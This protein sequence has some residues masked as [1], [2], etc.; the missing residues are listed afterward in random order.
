VFQPKTRPV[1][2]KFIPIAQVNFAKG[3]ISTLTDSRMP[4]DG[5]ARM[6]NMWLEQDSVPRPRPPFIKYGQDYLGI[7]IGQGTF[8]KI[9]AGRP[10]YWEISMQVV[11]GVAGVYIRKDGGDW[12]GVGGNY[13]T[14]AWTTFTPA[15]AINFS[16]AEDARVYISNRVNNMSYYDIGS[17]TI[18]QYTGLATPSAPTVVQ[19][20]L[21][22][23]NFTQYYR[24]TANNQGGESAAS[25]SGSVPISTA[26]DFWGSGESITVSWPTVTGAQSYSI[27]TADISGQEAYL[28]TV[29][30]TTFK[31]DGTVAI[32]VFKLAPNNDSS[33]G[34]KLGQLINMDNQLFG[35]DDPD[36]PSYLWYSG[37]AQH[38]GDFS[39]N[40]EGGGYVGIDYGGDTLPTIPFSFQDGKGNPV[41]SILTHGAAGRGKLLHMTFTTTQ[42]GSTSVTYPNVYEASSKDG[43]PAP[44]GV[45]IYN[46][47]AYYCT[48]TAF[49][50]TGI[51]PNV[52]NILSTD[53]ISNQL[54]PDLARI[55]LAALAGASALEYLGKIYFSLPVDGSSKNNTVWILDLTRGGL[56]ILE[57]PV[58]IDHMWLY[59]DN[60]GDAHLVTLQNNK[61]LELDLK[62][63]STPTQDN[64][65]PFVTDLRSGAMVFDKGGVAMFS[66]YFTYFKFLAVQGVIDVSID[67]IVQD[68][69]V[70]QTLVTGQINAQAQIS[71]T[72]FGQMT[73]SNPGANL[74]ITF[75]GNVGP[76]IQTSVAAQT[77]PLE[78]DEIVNQESW[79]ITTNQA[80]CDYL[81]SS[82]TTT[83]YSIPRLYQGQ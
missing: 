71:R 58:S 55:N 13:D 28:A 73:F 68:S 17:N 30:G 39:F 43:T 2:K 34:P 51:K 69:N 40:P 41:L 56:W 59:E 21:T 48:G 78:V 62:R 16:G 25:A 46:N 1:N 24:I 79:E 72:A 52:I 6:V 29:S 38:L 22:G 76:V 42:V 10:Q 23:S 11:G 53:T 8:T 35:C 60:Q 7:C 33:S 26:R 54:I 80:G 74:P 31:D 37:Q 49:K 18:I 14:S 47:N 64:G 5:L 70:A 57:W 83:G 19:S 66:S 50:T 36:N 65:E 32:N 81:L 44:R 12:T 20:G 27:Y 63:M 75:S 67:G 45:A 3:Y 4:L 15:A 77:L 9:V 82:V 61:A